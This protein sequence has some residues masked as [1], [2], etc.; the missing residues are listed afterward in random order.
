M[1]GILG[2]ATRGGRRGSH[3]K[4]KGCCFFGALCTLA[5]SH[6]AFAQASATPKPTSRASAASQYD[7]R[8][9]SIEA[10]RIGGYATSATP[11]HSPAYVLP[12]DTWDAY[13]GR[14]RLK[15][16]LLEFYDAVDRPDLR[17]KALNHYILQTS[18]G[19]VGFGLVLGGGIYEYVHLNREP[20]SAPAGG[21]IMMGA[22]LACLVTAYIIGPRPIPADEAVALANQ[23]NARI[24][25]ELGLPQPIDGASEHD[26]LL[27][28]V[29]T[30]PAL[31]AR[32]GTQGFNLALNF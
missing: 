22:G 24:R 2:D 27:R 28:F 10:T 7:A 29:R 23:H 12:T 17:S 9:I 16:G 20:S 19:V 3:A 15:L 31:P 18:F 26:R 30:A 14:A 25:V 21:W 4:I 11:G 1:G 5:L 13:Q 8:Y 32:L 6:S